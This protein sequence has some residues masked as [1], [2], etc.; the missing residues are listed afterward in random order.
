M[1]GYNHVSCG[2][3]AGLATLPLAPV[4][5]WAAQASWVVALGGASLIPDLDTSG[6]SAARMWGPLTGAVS[7]VVAWVARGHRRGTHDALLGP[8]AF[9]LMAWLAT[10][11]PISFGVG[12]ALLIGLSL[13]GLA[14]A[15]AGQ[16]G[17][18]GNLLLSSAAAWWLV[19]HGAAQV[20]LLPLVVAA[21]VLVHIAGDWVTT[22]GVPVPVVWIADRRH[23][24]GLGLFEVNNPLERALVA[25]ALSLAVVALLLWRLD[26][27]DTPS[28]LAVVDRL[29]DQLRSGMPWP[30]PS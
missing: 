4:H 3:L 27:H 16:L 6:S 19:V 26:I 28:L 13:R 15:G 14:L 5:G 30:R 21:G 1:M 29:V 7:V 24:T 25:P 18:V 20:Q 22:E 17:V 12:L 8:A 11:H 23:R 10:L 2:V 9:A